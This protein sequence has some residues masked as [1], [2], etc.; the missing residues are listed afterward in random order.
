VAG[1]ITSTE[2][3]SDL[4][5]NRTRVSLR[6]H[7][8]WNIAGSTTATGLLTGNPRNRGSPLFRGRS[9]FSSQEHLDPPKRLLI[10]H[11]GP[12]P[13]EVELATSVQNMWSCASIS[14][15]AFPARGLIE[16]RDNF[17]ASCGDGDRVIQR[18]VDV[19]LPDYTAS[20]H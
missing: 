16:H 14:S 9:F 20:W 11:K 2:N 1:R 8:R 15:R 3:S 7:N 17:A 5:E 10:Q 4:T 13:S 18:S 19:N 12:F 6:F